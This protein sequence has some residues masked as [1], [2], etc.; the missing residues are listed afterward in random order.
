MEKFNYVFT[1]TDYTP[2]LVKNGKKILKKKVIA[3]DSFNYDQFTN[4]TSIGMSST[5]IRRS[6]IGTIRFKKIKICEDYLFKCKIL[7]KNNIAVKF[8]QNTMFYQISK[9]SL[10]SSKLRNLFWVWYI[11][12]NHNRMSL[13]KNLKSILFIV[14]SSIKRYGIK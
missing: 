11:N 2:F 12:K 8:N 4:N 13:F 5:I 14:M 1:Y 9:N 6:V 7:K 3:P 10:Q